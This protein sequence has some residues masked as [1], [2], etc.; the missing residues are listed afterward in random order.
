[1]SI[2]LK[3]I[4]ALSMVAALVSCSALFMQY[5]FNQQDEDAEI[6]NIAG[7]QRMLSQ[8][9]ALYANR[10]VLE[11]NEQDK[12]GEL[13]LDSTQRFQENHQYLRSLSLPPEITEI[14]FG[15]TD[16]DKRVSKY[17][18]R[19]KEFRQYPRNEALQISFNANL[20]D[21]LLSD[22]NEV[23]EHFENAAKERVNQI[24]NIERT[25]WA[26]TLF[27]LILEAI[28]IF[29][30]MELQIKSKIAK[31]IAQTKRAET[32]ELKANEASKAKSEFLASMSHELRTPMN[33]MFGMMELALDN[34]QKA[35]DYLKKAKNSGKQL[36]VLINDLLD[37]SKIEAGKLTLEQT[38]FELMQTLDE[39]VAVQEVH[40]RSKGLE[41]EFQKVTHVPQF[42]I[43]DPTRIA[44]ILNNLLNNAVKFTPSG[45]ITLQ[46][47]MHIKDKKPWLS[48]HVIDTGIGIAEE[49]QQNIFDKFSQADQST[50]RH[51]GGTGLGLAITK[52]LVQ[53]MEGELSVK[54]ELGK[55]SQFSISLPTEIHNS[56]G[57]KQFQ[58]SHIQCAVVDDLH[59]SGEYLKNLITN[60]GMECIYFD[61][62]VHFLE[63]NCRPDILLM[64]YAMP[65]MDG[66]TALSELVKESTDKIPYVIFVTAVLEQLSIPNELKAYVWQCHPKPILRKELEHDLLNLKSLIMD[67]VDDKKGQFV[68]G[69][70]VLLVED[71]EINAEIAKTMLESDGH[72]IT[73]ASDG[74]KAVNACTHHTF[75]I[76]FMDMSMPVMDGIEATKIIRQKLR[77]TTPIVALTANAFNEDKERCAEAGMDGFLSKPIDKK[78]L[79]DFV[80]KTVTTS[81]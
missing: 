36:L 34:P 49:K 16:L 13:L 29:R 2:R 42:V 9:I 39:V 53:I 25:L 66:I 68:Q 77:V 57:G 59:T 60:L 35:P 17:I 45:K 47:A 22:L 18:E 5:I 24:K 54:S 48:F 3:Y 14:Y 46:V 74:E 12:Y 28:F 50:T 23:V 4:L 8:R 81:S 7:Q 10:L 21:A 51:F 15:D 75:D 55:G 31:L 58:K 52:H 56:E 11:D 73:L 44:Q 30:P 27:L 64:D 69:A 67:K 62:P 71:N 63:A 80:N 6:I 41:F 78:E 40:C 70:Q 38:A 61:S 32:A 19:A 72:S 33:G 43:G 37:F 20:T 26:L 1:M 76:I 65:D 79:L